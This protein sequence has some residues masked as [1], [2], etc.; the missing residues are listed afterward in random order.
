MYLM[1]PDLSPMVGWET[2][3]P[4][5]PSLMDANL[6]AL[7]YTS[8]PPVVLYQ[9]DT[10]DPLN[11]LGLLMAYAETNWVKPVVSDMDALLIGSKGFRYKPH[12]EEQ[13]RLSKWSLEKLGSI[14]E[15]PSAMSWH[16]RWVQVMKEEKAKGFIA[17][18][19]KYGFG[20]PSSEAITVEVVAATIDC[21][22]VRHGA[23]CFNYLAPQIMDDNF[24]IIW[25]GYTDPPW[26]AVTEPE[27]RQFLIDRVKDGFTFPI[28]PM[29][30]VRDEGWY[31]VMR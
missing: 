5:E 27:L 21:G 30:P 11:P 26:Q 12:T 24:L 4:S 16:Q 22:A 15:S 3:R 29:W 25:D 18:V 7:R 8:L 28:H 13:V 20:D 6:C 9:N 19:P 1:Q 2:G 17:S 23:E 31:E 14:L 10:M